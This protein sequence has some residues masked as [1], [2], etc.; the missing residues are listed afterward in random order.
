MISRTQKR[1]RLLEHIES[2]LNAEERDEHEKPASHLCLETNLTKYYSAREGDSGVWD[3]FS[4]EESAHRRSHSDDV[5]SFCQDFGASGT[6]PKTPRSLRTR[7]SIF[8]DVILKP[9]SVSAK[10]PGSPSTTG[11]D[12]PVSPAVVKQRTQHYAK[13]LEEQNTKKRAAQRGK[14]STTDPHKHKPYERTECQCC[15]ATF[16]SSSELKK[17]ACRIAYVYSTSQ[18]NR[19]LIQYFVSTL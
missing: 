11:Y 4:C 5:S 1:T 15:G 2:V 10:H 3:A 16:K 13:W 9:R 6:L 8:K 18:Q 17:H 12:R 7:G 19:I 14:R